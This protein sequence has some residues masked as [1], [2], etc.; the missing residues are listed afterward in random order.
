MNGMEREVRSKKKI[1]KKQKQENLPDPHPTH[2]YFL[3]RNRLPMI[4]LIS[5]LPFN[6]A[7]RA[8]LLH[9]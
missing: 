1:L 6:I 3:L 2:Q 9:T 8:G 4:R 7:A 5:G